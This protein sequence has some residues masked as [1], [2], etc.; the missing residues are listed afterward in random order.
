M[1]DEEIR[2]IASDWVAIEKTQGRETSSQ[3]KPSD[4]DTRWNVVFGLMDLAHDDWL[5][6]T[7]IC[8]EIAT[9]SDDPYVLGMLGAGPLEDL[10]EYHGT[11]VIE[12]FLKAAKTNPRFRQALRSV[13]E[14]S[15]PEVWER[16]KSVR[17]TLSYVKK[18]TSPPRHL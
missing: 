12:P 11:H 5:T 3:P 7:A 2:R 4:D 15:D 9:Q 17:D 1:D 14:C 16:F 6:A 8:E 10:L 13:W 18:P